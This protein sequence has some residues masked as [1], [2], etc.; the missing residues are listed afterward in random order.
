[1]VWQPMPPPASEPSGTAVERLC[2]Q[3]EQ[4][5]AVRLVGSTVSGSGG[6]GGVFSGT[7][8]Q[9]AAQRR[10]QA[11][12]GQLAVGGHQRAAV[13]V[14]LAEDRGALPSP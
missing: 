7:G 12:R 2:G 6:G 5:Y 3:P 13:G 9:H 4:K 8:P 10:E 1:M 14:P 11:P